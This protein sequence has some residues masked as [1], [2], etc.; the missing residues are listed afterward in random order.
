MPKFAILCAVALAHLG[1]NFPASAQEEKAAGQQV[2]LADGKLTLTAPAD[3]KKQQPSVRIIEAEFAIPAVPGD[4]NDGRLTIMAAGGG[5]EANIDRWI[6]QFSQ[7][8]GK[9][10]KDQTKTDKITVAGQD[11]HLVDISGTYK[12]QRGPFAPAQTYEN[13][14]MLAAIIS[15]KDAGRYFLKLY[16]PKETIAANEKAF[17]RLVESLDVK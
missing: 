17:R 13:Y 2:T 16:G 11:V 8:D 3:W 10:T 9:S 1:W 4:K 12:D 15:T 6:G 7:P 5:V 14:R